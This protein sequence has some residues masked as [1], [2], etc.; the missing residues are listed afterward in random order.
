MPATRTEFWAE[1][2]EANRLRDE[3]VQQALLDEGWNVA[4]VW[5]CEV[6]DKIALSRRLTAFLQPL[7]EMAEVRKRAR[8]KAPA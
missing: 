2:L 7:K 3:K 4:V 6:R 8:I 5:E 1:K